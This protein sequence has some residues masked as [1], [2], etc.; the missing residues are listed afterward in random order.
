VKFDHS[1]IC[2]TVLSYDALKPAKLERHLKSVHPK[3][4]DQP[5]EFFIGKS[6]NLKKIKLGTRGSRFEAN[7]KVL[8]ASFKISQLIAK[9]KKSHTIGE[10][11]LKSCLLT[12]VE[13]ILGAEAKKK[14]QEIPLSNNTVKDRIDKMSF[15][16][17]E[18][19]LVKIKK[20]RL[21]THCSVMKV[22][23]F[24]NVV[25]YWFLFNFW[26]TTIY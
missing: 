4:S 17:E 14:I 24:H 6:E 9:S 11:L 23:M 12:A 16:I 8:S 3:F 13:E 25:S 5:P 22:L 2:A 7:E 18:Q 1:V 15:D 10:N 19:L 20:I 26:T 21:F